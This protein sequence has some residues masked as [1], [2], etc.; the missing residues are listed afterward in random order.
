M[1]IMS[2]PVFRTGPITIVVTQED[3][4][5]GKPRDGDR[6]PIAQS[7]IRRGFWSVFASDGG[8]DTYQEFFD[9]NDRAITFMND[10]DNG[11]P[12][13]PS[14]FTFQQFDSRED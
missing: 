11:R 1:W 4:D 12:V 14:R 9:T 8:V 10:F 2:V 5:N 7:F 3:I 13:K 6:C